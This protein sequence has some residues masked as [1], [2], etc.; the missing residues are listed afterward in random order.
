MLEE[1]ERIVEYGILKD[2]EEAVRSALEEGIT[3]TAVLDTMINALVKVGERYQ[4][5]ELFVPDMLISAMTMQRG[6]GI[7]KPL[8]AADDG[9]RYGKFIIGTVRGDLHDIGKN[10]VSMMVSAAGFQVIDLG[11]DVPPE[12]FI[13][14]IR[15]NPDCRVVG[16]SALLTTT[17][18][19][20]RKTVPAIT[21]AGRRSQ[22]KIMVGG[23]PVTQAFADRIGADV[24]TSN[25]AEAAIK[26]RELAKEQES[27]N[28]SP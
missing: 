19:A 15:E 24:H 5:K 25:A 3:A 4:R 9:S 18:E 26:A 16:V 21:E 22:V 28:A 11:V 8:F 7:L 23:T 17:L 12:K 14:A 20:M 27:K 2:I 10:L 13:E 1:I 6:V